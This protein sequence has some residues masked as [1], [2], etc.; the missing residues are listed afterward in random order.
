MPI[1]VLHYIKAASVVILLIAF[2]FPLSRCSSD[3]NSSS[4]DSDGKNTQSDQNKSTYTYQYAWSDFNSKDASSWLILIV[5]FWPIPFIIY[6]IASKNVYRCIWIPLIQVLLSAGS[7]Y[8]IYLRT[9]L[10]EL[11]Y[12]GYLSYIAL[13]IFLLISIIEMI[14]TVRKKSL[15]EAHK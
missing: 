8:M 1:K 2:T 12:G 14:F 13:S 9:F 7:I 4:A 10:D 3:S 6:E 11:W 5:F 15:A